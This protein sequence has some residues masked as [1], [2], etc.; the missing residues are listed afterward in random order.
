LKRLILFDIDET[1]IASNGA[2]RRAFSSA[3]KQLHDI[4]D[5]A[6]TLSMSGK[7][8]PQ[9]LAE[10]LACADKT[11]LDHEK[12]FASLL[13]PYLTELEKEIATATNYIVHEGIWD[14][15]ER[16]NSHPDAY[17]GLLT[18]NVEKGAR[19]K[20]NRFGLNKYFA[21][22]AYGSDSGNRLDLPAIATQ[23]ADKYYKTRFRPDEVVIIG[24]SVNDVLCAKHFGARSI[25]VNTGKTS[26]ASLTEI[27]P[28][29][30]FETLRHTERVMKAIFC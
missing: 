20:L 29:F 2:G 27:Q 23:R 17:L 22:G 18:G 30:L 16:L 14:L 21:V 6:F 19:M 7:T 4:P 8:D 1:M 13:E 11:H 5:E 24:D 26:L 12:V 28:D 15:L 25:A 3:L 9:I 10:I